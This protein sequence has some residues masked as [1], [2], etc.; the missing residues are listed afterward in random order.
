MKKF[1]FFL[2]LLAFT[3]LSQMSLKA[4]TVII[5]GTMGNLTW[6]LTDD[7]TFIVRGS[8]A[9]WN[10]SYNTMPWY[11]HRS[12]IATV[13]IGDSVTSIGNDAFSSCSNLT[14]VTIPNSVVSI[15]DWA[16]YNC[17]SLPSVIIPCNVTNIGNNGFLR[18]SGLTSITIHVITPPAIGTSTFYGMSKNIPVYIPCGTH[19]NYTT[20]ANWGEFSNFIELTDTTSYSATISQ[21]GA[22]SD[23]NFI[24]LTQA[25]TYYDTLQSINGCDSIIELTLTIASVGIAETQAS[26]ISI[27]P[28]PAQNTLY[29][30][31]S[32]TIEQ[33]RV[34]DISGRELIQLPYPA[35][36]IDINHLATGIYLVK[37]RTAQGETIKKIVKQ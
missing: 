35:Q 8:G 37:V 17:S 2:T 3:G 18:C 11:L 28:N 10:Y 15:G 32:E 27:Y 26:T 36:S 34:Y 13:I 4:Q 20:P 5:Q 12:S 1:T 22:Y 33:V 30:Q 29:I 25:G 6:V 21:G 16:F 7:S 9:M 14:S 31:S 19:S 24:N 23:N